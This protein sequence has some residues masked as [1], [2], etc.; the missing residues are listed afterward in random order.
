MTD[1]GSTPTSGVVTRPADDEHVVHLLREMLRIRRFEERCVELYSRTAI[2]GFL[3]LGIGEEACAVGV[4][5]ALTPDDA[6]V[7]TYRE[8]GHALARGLSM[9][10][11]MAELEG[12]IEGCSR[13]RGGS[14]HLFDA[15]TRFYGGNAIVAGGLPLAVGLA[16]ADH[17]RGR[18]RVTACFFGDGAVAEG[19]FHESMNLASLWRLPVLFC[20]ENN[21]YAMGTALKLTESETDLSLKASSYR[22]PA[23]EVDGMDVLAVEEAA[24]QAAEAVRGGGG[25][26]FLEM[27]TYRFRAHSMYDPDRYRE[28]PEVE[29]WKERDPI[30][31]LVARLSDSGVLA[32]GDLD[33]MESEIASEVDDAVAFADAGTFEP[34]ED[35]ER[36][37]TSETTSGS[38][39]P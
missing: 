10:A 13:G 38:V 33:R 8:H 39:V 34:L 7:A 19:E 5:E 29:G 23:W 12:K 28:K 15:S 21:L 27:R 17:L 2:R 22:I 30:P 16:L 31:A 24:R 14:M 4:M 18:R 11:T 25:P 1:A 36:F 3:H 9:R 20:C 35:L 37:V 32:E 26:H 6:V